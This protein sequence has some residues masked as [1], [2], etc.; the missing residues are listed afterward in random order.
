MNEREKIIKSAEMCEHYMFMREVYNGAVERLNAEAPSLLKM[1]EDYLDY[2]LCTAARIFLLIAFLLAF[3]KYTNALGLLKA[4]D[5]KV[6]YTISIVSIIIAAMIYVIREVKCAGLHKKT[7][8]QIK[9][10][11]EQAE[12]RM[13][14]IQRDLKRAEEQVYNK[15]MCIIPNDYIQYGS[16]IRTIVQNGRASTLSTALNVLHMDLHNN[17][18]RQQIEDARFEAEMTAYYNNR[19]AERRDRQIREKQEDLQN[20]IDNLKRRM[21]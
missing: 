14:D 5:D 15:S 16:A 20:E 9:E 11:R 6:I 3:F 8:K 18:V 12:L 2:N 21:W 1:R 7:V 17:A 19:D 4:F 10:K 13:P